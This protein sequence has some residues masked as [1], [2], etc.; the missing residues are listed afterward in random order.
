MVYEQGYQGPVL[1]HPADPV[2]P[3][4]SEFAPPSFHHPILSAPREELAETIVVAPT[5]DMTPSY[6]GHVIEIP[7]PEDPEPDEEPEQP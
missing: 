6:E 4:R 2:A 1:A 3:G 5:M 7:L